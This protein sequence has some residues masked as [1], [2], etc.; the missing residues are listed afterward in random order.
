M[1]KLYAT[2]IAVILFLIMDAILQS[3]EQ[4]NN[5]KAVLMMMAAMGI[6]GVIGW[7]LWR[8]GE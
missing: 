4:L 7:W 6:W 1:N 3:W 2:C 8:E 5:L